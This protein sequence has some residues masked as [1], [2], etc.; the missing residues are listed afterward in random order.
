[1][2]AGTVCA[3]KRTEPSSTSN[4]EDAHGLL[5]SM[6]QAISNSGADIESVDTPTKA[7]AGTEGFVEFKFTIK[8]KDLD[9]VNQIIHAMHANPNIRK[10]IRG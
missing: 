9:Q 6:A 4:P 8:V 3:I 2:R 7:Q 1:M 10:V 5:A